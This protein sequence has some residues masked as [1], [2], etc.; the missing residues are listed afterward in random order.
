[1]GALLALAAP[2]VVALLLGPGYEDAVPVLRVLA[3]LVPIIAVGTVLGLFWALPFGRDR[4]LLLVTATA[5]LVNVALVVV[6]VPRM[7]ALGMAALGMASAVV[8]AELLVAVTLGVLYARWHP[9]FTVDTL[10]AS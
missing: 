7:A 2:T 1:M 8:T 3:L 4:V 6:L 10:V 9:E 5:G